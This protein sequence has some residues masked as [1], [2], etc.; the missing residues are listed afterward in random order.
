MR[1]FQHER[2]TYGYDETQGHLVAAAITSGWKEV[3][4][5]WP[6]AA[7]PLPAVSLVAA[8]QQALAAVDAVAIKC[9]KQGLP[10]PEQYRAYDAALTAIVDGVDTTSATLPASPM[11]GA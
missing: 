10:F 2:R 3:T 6:P 9:Y 7:S 4:G 5:Q 8:A 1:Y 11:V